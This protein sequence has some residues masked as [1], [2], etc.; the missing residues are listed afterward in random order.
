MSTPA[1]SASPGYQEPNSGCPSLV[2]Q[3][4]CWPAIAPCGMSQ[5]EQIVAADNLGV[6]FSENAWAAAQQEGTPYPCPDVYPRWPA[7]GM[8][9]QLD[10]PDQM[11]VGMDPDM[12]ID[13]TPYL[14]QRV[15]PITF[16]D[17]AAFADPAA[18][19]T[20]PTLPKLP[21]LPASPKAPAVTRGAPGPPTAGVRPL[22][23]ADQP[24]FD[25]HFFPLIGYGLRGIWYHLRH[26][27]EI[28]HDSFFDKLKFALFEEDR[29]MALAFTF[30]GALVLGT[31]FYLLLGGTTKLAAPTRSSGEYSRHVRHHFSDN[32]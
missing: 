22:S 2:Q 15:M 13:N 18:Y 20:L 19:P 4:E 11:V 29:W 28:P 17:P 23:M 1:C 6:A 21:S 27:T 9:Q 16:N 7:P 32:E 26:F 14:Q 3:G 8:Y 5:S 12:A 31:I 24:S 10:T 30:I 25:R